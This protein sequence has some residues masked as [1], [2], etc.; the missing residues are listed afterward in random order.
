[1]SSVSSRRCSLFCRIFL[2]ILSTLK[3]YFAIL[4]F[5]RFFFTSLFRSAISPSFPL[6]ACG[7][8]ICASVGQRR[9]GVTSKGT[10]LRLESPRKVRDIEFLREEKTKTFWALDTFFYFSFFVVSV[11]SEFSWISIPFVFFH[12][13]VRFV[14]LVFFQG[15]I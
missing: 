14:F 9:E 7:L 10:K 12:F 15:R 3:F 11:P 6:K 1:M 4:F 5:L 2:C 8:G 13:I